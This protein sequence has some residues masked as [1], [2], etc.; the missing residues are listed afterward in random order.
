MYKI[1]QKYDY[2]QQNLLKN[3]IETKFQTPIPA[4]I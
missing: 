1:G 2:F 4:V 3:K